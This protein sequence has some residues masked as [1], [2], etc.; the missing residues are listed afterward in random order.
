ML[1]V[2][3]GDLPEQRIVYGEVYAPNRP[4]AQGE[5][6]RADE[7]RKMAHNFVKS[8]KIDQIDVMHNNQLVACNIVESF[9]ARDNDIDFLA[10]S[11]VIG[12]HVPDDDLW[13]QIKK[14]EINGFSME[15]VVTRHEQEVDIEI[16]PIVQGRTSKSD[17]HEHQFFVSYDQKG[18]FQGGVTSMTDGHQ[19]K[20]LAGT[21]T[22]EA[23]EHTHR[24]SSVDDLTVI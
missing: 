4:D 24:F 1:L 14:G 5:F 20:I 10:G 19:H 23:N 3:K 8:K 21:H 11:W 17:N 15:A 6:M 9:I 2:T 12:M 16:P 7:I 18:V 13:E 22:E